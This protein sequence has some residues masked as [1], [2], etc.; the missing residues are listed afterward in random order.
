MIGNGDRNHEMVLRLLKNTQKKNKLCIASV[1]TDG[2]DGNTCFAGATSEN[3]LVNPML[4]KDYLKNNDSANFFRKKKSNVIT[5]FTH[6][7]LMD[8]GLVLQ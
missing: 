8:I 3:I 2:I 6:C 4:V 7:N 5:G 1:G